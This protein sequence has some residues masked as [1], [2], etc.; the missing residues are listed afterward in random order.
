MGSTS[1]WPEDTPFGKRVL[2]TLID[3]VAAQEPDR[4]CM[5]TPRSDKP[6]DGWKVVTWRDMA[7]A[8]NRCA[9]RIVELC[10]KPEE[11]S[12]PT[13]A[14]LGTNDIRYT[15]T[16]IACVK[17]GYKVCLVAVDPFLKAPPSR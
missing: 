2:P 9:H 8:I 1:N 3:Q 4:E 12:F 7:N 13:I 15:I 17:A 16:M 14:Y 5:S 10:G 6:S 11:D